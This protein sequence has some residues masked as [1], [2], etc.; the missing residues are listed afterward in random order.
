MQ[1]SGPL[2]M[3]IRSQVGGYHLDVIPVTEEVGCRAGFDDDGVEPGCG[4]DP[5]ASD[6]RP[7]ADPA[8][9]SSG[10]LQQ[11]PPLAY[12][13]RLEHQEQP[14]GRERAGHGGEGGA[15]DRLGCKCESDR[16]RG[17]KK[18]HRLYGPSEDGQ[19]L[20]WFD[21]ASGSAGLGQEP[22][23]VVQVGELEE[24]MERHPKWGQVPARETKC[25]TRFD[26]E[27]GTG[28]SWVDG[29]LHVPVCCDTGGI[30]SEA[31]IS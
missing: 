4:A 10:L 2:E 17:L 15:E 16:G 31:G 24:G 1:F 12:S 27:T 21:G 30:G 28:R 9:R 7:D 13:G 25:G 14:I 8:R 26:T 3:S 11:V 18:V 20:V 5:L 23:G 29:G 6:R 22:S 19:A